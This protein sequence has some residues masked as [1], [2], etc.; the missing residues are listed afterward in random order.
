MLPQNHIYMG[1]WQIHATMMLPI[2]VSNV[3]IPTTP[4]SI[5]FRNAWKAMAAHMLATLGKAC[6]IIFG[7]IALEISMRHFHWLLL[8]C[9]APRHLLRSIDGC[10]KGT[11]SLWF[12]LESVHGAKNT[13]S[14][15]SNEVVVNKSGL[16][17][18]RGMVS[19]G[20]GRTFPC[21]ILK[22]IWPR[23]GRPFKQT[24]LPSEAL[25]NYGR[26]KN[27]NEVRDGKGKKGR[28]FCHDGY[29]TATI[30]PWCNA[31][32]FVANFENLSSHLGRR[33][34]PLRETVS[35]SERQLHAKIGTRNKRYL[36]FKFIKF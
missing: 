1:K 16:R 3:C 25:G 8:G 24:H 13:Q 28:T 11:N 36:H 18:Y 22:K 23:Q 9:R 26:K 19:D 2:F 14:T 6:N 20:W 32:W 7:S 12:Q 30:D 4:F 17:W 21:Q 34:P 29:L 10:G 31:K 33:P 27:W 5:A 15:D 35:G